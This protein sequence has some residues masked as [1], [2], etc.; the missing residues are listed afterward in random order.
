MLALNNELGEP[1]GVTIT[2]TR[3]FLEHLDAEA[4]I[5]LKLLRDRQGIEGGVTIPF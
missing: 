2:M 1:L 5:R 3:K 4:F